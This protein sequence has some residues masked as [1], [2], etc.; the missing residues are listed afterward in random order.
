MRLV[1]Y[2]QHTFENAELLKTFEDNVKQKLQLDP[3]DGLLII[4][5]Q[6]RDEVVALDEG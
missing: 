6:E 1:Y 5:G 2:T 3:R 4:P